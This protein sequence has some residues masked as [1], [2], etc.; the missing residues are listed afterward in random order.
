[1]ARRPPAKGAPRPLHLLVYTDAEIVGGAERVVELL[2][3]SLDERISV[4]VVGTTDAVVRALASE[5]PGTE[6]VLVRPPLAERRLDLGSVVDHVRALR[7]LSGNLLHVNLRTPYACDHA[8]VAASAARIPTLTVEHLPMAGRSRYRHW[9]KRRTSQ[10]LRAHVA[11]GARVARMVE[12]DARLPRSSIGVIHNGVPDGGEGP[13]E[14]LASGPVIGAI[15]RLDHQ[16]GFDVLI[17]ALS[18]LPRV[19]VVIVGDGPE[20]SALERRAAKAGVQDRLLVTGWKEDVAPLLRGFDVFALPSRYEGLPLGL[21][22][23][24]SAGLPIVATDVGSVAEAVEPEETGLLV[25]AGDSLALAAGA[26]R[27]LD[28]LELRTRL[29]SQARE[30]WTA[31]FDVTPMVQAYEQLYWGVAR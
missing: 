18:F 10:R 3:A 17:D 26:K 19:T 15:G 4:T 11:V 2:L 27:L 21:L 16:K 30:A 7:R 12:D 5:R 20:R 6:S 23:A 9:L 28:D 22:E 8:L 1:M 13:T 31:K 24:M 25:P 14:R 29:G